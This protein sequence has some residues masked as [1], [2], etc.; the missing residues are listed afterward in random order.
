MASVFHTPRHA[1]AVN[2]TRGR[3]FTVLAVGLGIVLS[4]AV[5][6]TASRAAFSDTTS[7]SNNSFTTGT[8]V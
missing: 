6:L 2:R 4:G 5:V 7:N 1:A 8:V 3:V